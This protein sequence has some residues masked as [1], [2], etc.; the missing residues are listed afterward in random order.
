MLVGDDG[1][2]WQQVKD[3]NN[4]NEK[5]GIKVRKKSLNEQ[6][7]SLIYYNRSIL[8]QH[9]SYEDFPDR[10]QE[11]TQDFFN[12]NLDKYEK[13]IEILKQEPCSIEDEEQIISQ[14]RYLIKMTKKKT[15]G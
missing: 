10:L 6:I 7:L 13:Q 3:N 4:K 8:E 5:D 9:F 1:K 11:V 14:F 2:A 15:R 12:N